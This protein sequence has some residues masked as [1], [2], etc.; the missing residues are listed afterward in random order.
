MLD[1]MKVMSSLE[2]LSCPAEASSQH[3]FCGRSKA[4][5]RLKKSSYLKT[6]LKSFSRSPLSPNSLAWQLRASLVEADLDARSYLA[7]P[8]SPKL[9]LWGNEC[10]SWNTPGFTTPLCF[11][12][13]WYQN[14]LPLCPSGK[15]PLV[16]QHSPPP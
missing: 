7:S 12:L 9:Q 4:C 3:P 13:Y 1:A 15:Y 6:R 8:H 10:C 2:M 14:I 5:H 16:F 11:C